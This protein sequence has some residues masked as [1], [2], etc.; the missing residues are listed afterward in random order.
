MDLSNFKFKYSR[1][2]KS[3]LFGNVL[4]MGLVQF[5]NY[6]LPLIL[7][8]Y[9]V[10]ILGTEI[11]GRVHYAQI[12]VSYFTLIVSY[13]LDYTATKEIAN[14]KNNKKL[15]S[16]A[17]NSFLQIRFLLFAATTIIFFISTYFFAKVK[18]DFLLYFYCYLINLGIVFFPN[19]FFQ[20]MENI[21]LMSLI[22]FGIKV[23]TTA[24]TFLLV[25][26]QNDY[27]F[28][29]V[30]AFAIQIAFGFWSIMY[31]VKK[32]DLSFNFNINEAYL[33][34]QLKLGFPIFISSVAI[35]SYTVANFTILGFFCNE[36][37]VGYYSGAYKIIMAIL[38]MISVPI[39]TSLYPM[40]SRKIKDSHE[41]GIQFLKKSLLLVG[42]ATLIL[43][44]ITFIS[45]PLMVKYILSEKFMGSI[46]YLKIFS[47]Q[48]FLVTIASMLTVQGLYNFGLQKYSPYVGISLGLFCFLFNY[49]L[50]PIYGGYV[51]ALAW[52]LA[53]FFEII[54]VIFILR[55]KNIRL[56]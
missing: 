24:L 15:I 47:F 11:Y 19:W 50:I 9:L 8:P 45:T 44:F 40:L 51:A 3:K 55:F 36:E 6:V 46:E 30:L 34:M 7:I 20:G 56:F 13:G 5:S 27:Y 12:F 18:E 32:Y 38:M 43:S 41:L 31:I 17:F 54:I 37:T 52:T 25:K 42:S 16:D 49:F 22:N 29:P 26:T 10:R 33:K 53:Q 48:P 2:R 39:N 23:F 21:K 1:Y 28:I 4:S 35:S 14:N